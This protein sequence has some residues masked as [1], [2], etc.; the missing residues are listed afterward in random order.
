M[1]ESLT[2]AINEMRNMRESY[3]ELANRATYANITDEVEAVQAIDD[4]TAEIYVLSN[5]EQEE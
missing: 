4:I 5:N 1:S 2:Q 3:N